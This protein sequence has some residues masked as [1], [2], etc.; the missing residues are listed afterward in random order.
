MHELSLAENIVQLIEDTALKQPF[1]QVKTVWLE[2]GQLACVEQESL[3]FYFDVV[4]QDSIARQ[5][6]LEIIEVAGQA[7]C[8]QCNQDILIT[9]YHEA[10]PHCGSYALQV[11]Q[12]DGMRIKE[13]EVE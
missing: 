13:I 11:I 7:L 10:C 2:I 1:S 12:G 6:R 3:R 9:A 5:A 8:Q 4:T